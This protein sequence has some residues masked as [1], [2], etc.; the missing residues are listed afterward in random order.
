MR[1]L[2]APRIDY[3]NLYRTAIAQTQRNVERSILESLEDRIVQ[4]A[5]D[6]D[7][8][9]STQGPFA[10]TAIQLSADEERLA[11]ALYEKRVVSKLGACRAA[12][13]AIRT[14]TAHCPYCLDGEVYEV[15]HFLPQAHHPDVVMYPGNLVPICHPCNHIKHHERPVGSRESFLHPYFDALPKVPWLFA[16]LDRRSGGPVLNYWVDLD[17]TRYGHVAPRLRHHFGRLEMDRRMRE[18]SAKVLVELESNVEKYLPLLTS[19]GLKAYFADEAR[20]R[21]ERQGNALE[22]AAYRAASLNE[23]FCAG[24]YRN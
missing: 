6:Y 14:S 11:G 22:A 24:H 1:K 5:A 16:R 3:R 4:A 12:Y 8:T 20:E 19:A 7:A 21:F 9:M 23:D 2:P 17:E 18:R 10:I 13:D 15:D